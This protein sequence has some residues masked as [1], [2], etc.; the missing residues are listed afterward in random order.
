LLKRLKFGFLITQKSKNMAIGKIFN[1]EKYG[2]VFCPDCEGK[3]KLPKNPDC[4]I[5]CSRCGGCGAIRKEKEAR[6]EDRK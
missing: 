6:E 3:G 2:M 1:P 5:V 4:F